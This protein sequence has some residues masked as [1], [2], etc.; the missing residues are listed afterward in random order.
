MTEYTNNPRSREQ[1]WCR[2]AEACPVR[3]SV[4][5]RT[6]G[7]RI[8]ERQEPGLQLWFYPGYSQDSFATNSGTPTPRSQP[9]RRRTGLWFILEGGLAAGRQLFDGD[10]EVL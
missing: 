1:P 10:G 2:A 8:S 3:V 7:T 6:G 4:L 5:V 9:R